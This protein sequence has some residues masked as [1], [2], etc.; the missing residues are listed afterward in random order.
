MREARIRVKAFVVSQLASTPPRDTGGGEDRRAKVRKWQAELQSR[1][2]EV[3]E[4][5]TARAE[6]GTAQ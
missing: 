6:G 3:A 4:P 5:S 2:G 1:V